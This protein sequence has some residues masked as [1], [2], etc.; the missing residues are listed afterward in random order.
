VVAERARRA[1]E[2][3]RLD[4]EI[5]QLRQEAA[6]AQAR[7]QDRAARHQRLTEEAEELAAE[8]KE[9]EEKITR[10]TAEG[11]KLTADLESAERLHQE[12][13]REVDEAQTEV[14]A[15]KGEREKLR[16][17][18]AGRRGELKLLTERL[19]SH[20]REAERLA[21]E[22]TEGE[23]LVRLWRE[24]AERLDRRR[25]ELSGQIEAAESELQELLEGQSAAQEKVLAAQ[26]RL[27][28]H[29][30]ALRQLEERIASRRAAHDTAR[31]QVEELRVHH[32]E[33]KQEAGHLTAAFR[34]QLSREPTAEPGPPPAE[35]AEAE[36]ELA[37]R[38]EALDRLGPV[39]VLAV[40][41]YN[42]QEERHRF[43]LEQRADVVASVESLR[44]TI[45]EINQTSS[46][47]FRETFAE[48]NVSFGEIYQRLFR[49]G[50][51][52]M[53]LQDED[54]LLETGIEIVARP[55]GKRLQ[56]I[57]LLSGGEK[58]L[59]AIAL[60]FALFRTKPS[61]FCILDEVDAPL[62]DS[63]DLRFAQILKEMSG[64]TQFIVITHNKIT[65][66]I[67]GTLYGVTMQERGVSQVVAVELD[68]VQPLAE[69][70]EQAATA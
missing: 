51:A 18:S 48:V 10:L 60:L 28:E 34:E 47:R 30:A 8:R 52:E 29:R 32:A 64:E 37:R 27:D 67:A 4:D 55:P 59:T 57:M 70:Q 23:R 50:E 11:E 68:E 22:V 35:L 25:Q 21:A 62:D 36:A 45:R 14:D 38:K 40:D 2:V 39:N 41:E 65:M 43:L 56:N 58:A 63:N 69:E 17:A 46:A 20:D 15:V 26:G 19:S 7:A 61:P 13:T 24:E 12:L 49:G 66:E 42:E 54:D 6:I 33:L 53:R 31:S 5:A 16:T 1:E 9:I 44:K 3:R